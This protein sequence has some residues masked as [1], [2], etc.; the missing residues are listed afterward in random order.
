MGGW[1]ALARAGRGRV[2]CRSLTCTLVPAGVAEQVRLPVPA[3]PGRQA[4]AD[5]GGAVQGSHRHAALWGPGGHRR[6]GSVLGGQLDTRSPS[7]PS[8]SLVVPSGLPTGCGRAGLLSP[9]QDQGFLPVGAPRGR[10]R[11]PQVCAGH[12]QHLHW[13]AGART[14]PLGPGGHPGPSLVL[15][16]RVP[17]C[18]AQTP[19]LLGTRKSGLSCEHPTFQTLA[20]NVDYVRTVFWAGR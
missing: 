9:G 6:A 11:L 13:A 10:P 12:A 2:P 8:R 20:R 4:A 14:L 18:A 19:S 1:E 17:A 5:A 7:P 16:D 3:G 15:P